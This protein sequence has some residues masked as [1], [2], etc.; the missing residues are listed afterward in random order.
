MRANEPTSA[1]AIDAEVAK[2]KAK[3]RAA[4]NRD[5]RRELWMTI[6]HFRIRGNDTAIQPEYETSD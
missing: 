4:T 3:F 5:L 1:E 2:L 6:D